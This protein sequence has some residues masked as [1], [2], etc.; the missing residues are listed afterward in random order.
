MTDSADI[1]AACAEVA[2]DHGV[3]LAFGV[4]GGGPNLELID[5]L[6]RRG[7]RFVL[8]HSETGAAIM[9]AAHGH[10][11]GTPGLAIATRGPGVTAAANGVAQATLDRSPLLF[12]TD[13]VRSADRE[14]VGHQRFDQVAAMAPLTKASGVL[15]HQDPSGT[16]AEA[17]ELAMAA[18]EGAVHLEVDPSAAGHVTA[19]RQATGPSDAVDQVKRSIVGAVRPLII[20]GSGALRHLRSVRAFIE[21]SGCPVLTTYQATGV[22]GPDHP[23]YGGIFTN[24]AS[25][26]LL[27]EQ[28]DLII[29]IG[30]DAVEPIPAAWNY[31]MPV[32]M[33]SDWWPGRYIPSARTVVGSVEETLAAIPPLSHTWPARSAEQARRGVQADLRRADSGFGPIALV[34]AVASAMPDQAI[35]TVDAGAHFLAVMPFWPAHEPDEVLISNGLAT[36][37]FAVPAAIG[38][39]LARPGRPVVAFVGDGGLGM[40]LAEL[41]SIVRLDLPVTV[42]VFN[43]NRLSL[44]AIKQ[45]AAGGG[46]G[47]VDYAPIDFSAVARGMG[48]PA[49]VATSVAEVRH[50]LSAMAPGPSLVDARIDPGAYPELIR[51]TRG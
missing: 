12:L 20:V 51:I 25:E 37:G 45:G 34:E 17:I 15:G 47:A 26:R 7:V 14:R 36:M 2:A 29:S 3:T 30:L 1:A 28:A 44:I 33:V 16:V 35:A 22:L 42:V 21:D 5:A 24:G 23:Q 43:D 9:A 10:L 38:A 6:M 46:P 27:L 48:M 32:V 50:L 41:E 8:A 40:T 13:T 19:G 31:D 49:S 4:P 18:P 11:S 39:A